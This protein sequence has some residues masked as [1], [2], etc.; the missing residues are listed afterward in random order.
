LS[1]LLIIDNVVANV[2]AT[3]AGV[4]FLVTGLVVGG[5]AYL[6]TR[7]KVHQ[8]DGTTFHLCIS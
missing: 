4:G 3:I 6:A 1:G 8:H 7:Y 5:A 2:A